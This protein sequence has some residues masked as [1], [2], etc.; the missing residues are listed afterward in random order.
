MKKWLRKHI[1]NIV[2]KGGR[3]VSNGMIKNK[4]ARNG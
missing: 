2:V 4:G 1:H 3:M